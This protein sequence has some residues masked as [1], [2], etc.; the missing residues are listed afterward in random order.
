[1]ATIPSLD[2][3]TEQIV[4]DYSNRF[5]DDDV[6]RTSDNWKRQ[7]SLA[8][9]TTGLYRQIDINSREILPDLASIAGLERWGNLR[10][11]PR[12]GATAAKRAD[13]L[14]VVGTPGSS[15][16]SGTEL[17]H[18]D[19][20]RYKVTETLSIPV[21][22]FVDMDIEAITLGAIG[23][24]NAGEVLTFSAGPPLGVQDQ[25]ELQLD[26]NEEGADLEGI[27]DYRER[28]LEREQSPGMGGN[29]TDYVVWGEQVAGVADAY[30]FAVRDGLGTIDIVGLHVGRGSQRHL[31]SGERAALLA[32]LDAVR[33]VTVAGLRV[34]ETVS[35]LQSVEV[36]IEAVNDPAYRWDWGDQT[37]LV[38]AAW[39]G[40]TRTLQ[41]TGPRPADLEVGDRIVIKTATGTKNDGEPEVVEALVAGDSVVLARV[42]AVAPVPGDTIYA[43]GPLTATIRDKIL[44]H[45]D[46]LGPARG[47]FASGIWEGSLHTATLYQLAQ[48]TR[49]AANTVVLSPAADVDGANVAPST[50]IELITP[51][52]VIV[53][54]KW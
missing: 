32:Y 13:A 50:Q 10:A 35:L 21:A 30:V 27:E 53:R 52:R 23:R 37:P 47:A 8:L 18:V 46:N 11:L 15:I 3:T 33:P 39:T 22:G 54:R 9:A 31:S 48:G 41:F 28:I 1:M 26:I 14:R 20:T 44:E 49:G 34:L 40:A 7:R 42:P 24:K 51:E 43:G 12:K 36:L 38:V 25:P 29:A 4:N 5:P 45:M 19:G 2:E 6:S 17:V 16:T